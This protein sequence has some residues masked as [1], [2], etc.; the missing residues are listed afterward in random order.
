ME[1]FIVCTQG[2][3]GTFILSN[4]KEQLDVD[5]G[6]LALGE[7]SGSPKEETELYIRLL[8]DVYYPRHHDTQAAAVCAFLHVMTEKEISGNLY[9]KLIPEEGMKV[10]QNPVLIAPE[11]R[12]NM[13]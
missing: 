2:V 12:I 6:E 11:S 3:E 4:K 7:T 1:T 8:T 10:N 13:N 5:P 9:C